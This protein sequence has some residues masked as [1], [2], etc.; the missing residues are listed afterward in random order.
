M[1]FDEF[2]KKYDGRAVD[3]DGAAGVQ[4]VDLIDR[5]LEDV[6]GIK[7]VW[8]TGAREFY[9]KFLGYEAL[10]DSFERIPNTRELTVSKGDIVVWNGG[11]WGHV[12]IGTGR[13]STHWFESFEENTLGR[14]EP[15]HTEIHFFKRRTG[16]DCCAPVL[17]VLRAKDQSLVTGEKSF[18]RY[19]VRVTY[20]RGLNVRS[21]AGVGN[22]LVGYL[23]RGEVR[24]VT[25]EKRVGSQ[26]WGRLGNGGWI[27]LTGFT[28]RF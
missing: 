27:C 10:T 1:T 5:Y 8:V 13:G 25:A 23:S 16:A 7:G 26:V 9:T 17:G 3:Y 14:H 24:T 12:A 18:E 22:P 21:G 15:A 19:S 2:R 4:C 20:P 28:E 11:R 6:F